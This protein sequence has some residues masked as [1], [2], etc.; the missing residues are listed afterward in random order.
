MDSHD[1]NEQLLMEE[2]QQQQI[3]QEEMQE[4][5][6]MDEQQMQEQYEQDSQ[7]TRQQQQPPLVEAKGGK[8][9]VFMFKFNETVLVQMGRDRGFGRSLKLKEFHLVLEVD[10]RPL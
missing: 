6:Q 5:Y 1:P 7:E 8:S 2:Q 4:Q 9:M 10:T 3:M